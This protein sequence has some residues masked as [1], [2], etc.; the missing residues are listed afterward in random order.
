[1]ALLEA[2]RSR[3]LDAGVSRWD[4]DDGIGRISARDTDGNLVM[5]LKAGP[6]FGAQ[7][8]AAFASP[9]TVVTPYGDRTQAHPPR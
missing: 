7:L 4:F 1:M 2:H 5:A 3:G 6:M 8:A 9:G